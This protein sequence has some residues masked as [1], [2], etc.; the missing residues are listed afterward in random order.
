MSINGVSSSA[1][2]GGGGGDDARPA[3]SSNVSFARTSSSDDRS[4]ISHNTQNSEASL[5]QPARTPN[6]SFAITDDDRSIMSTNSEANRSIMSQNTQNSEASSTTSFA[7]SICSITSRDHHHHDRRKPPPQ[8]RRHSSQMYDLR[9]T[10]S[11]F[12]SGLSRGLSF[13]SAASTTTSSSSS[14]SRRNLLKRSSIRKS[15]RRLDSSHRLA[16]CASGS[17]LSQLYLSSPELEATDTLTNSTGSSGSRSNSSSGRRSSWIQ[18]ADIYGR[19]KSFR[20]LNSYAKFLD[21]EMMS[22]I[23]EEGSSDEEKM[24]LIEETTDDDDT[25][26]V[27]TKR[28]RR[29]CCMKWLKSP[30]LV[31]PT[32]MII[33]LI[34]G[35]GLSL[36]DS[37]LL[38]NVKGFKFPLCYALIQKLTNSLASLVLICLS[39]KWEMD[40]MAKQQQKQQ[41]RGN[42]KNGNVILTELPSIQTFRQHMIPLSAVALVQTISSAFANKALTIIPLPLFKVCLMCGPIFVAFIT[43]CVEGQLYSKGRLFALS[44]IGIGAA[45]AVYAESE[46]ADNPRYIMS[47]AGFA[48]AAS[49]FSGIGL[50]L[51]SVI[52]HHGSG[53]SGDADDDEEEEEDE[54]V[55]KSAVSKTENTSAELNPLSLLFY[56]SCVQ[57]L[58]L[59]G[60]LFPWDTLL[61][62]VG[63][64][65]IREEPGEFISFV[66]YAR[67]DPLTAMYYLMCGSM[68]SLTLAVLTFVL[69]NRTSPVATSLLGNARSIV[70]VAISSI[71]FGGGTTLASANGV[72][73]SAIFGYTLTLAGGVVY[74]LAALQS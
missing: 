35:V 2:K 15:L 59:S 47:G 16:C 1:H 74:A 54:H 24:L 40:A 22:D 67:A 11:A 36:Y 43:S 23:D 72:F 34:L 56:L 29:A 68:M 17:D 69:V 46:G 48:L 70:T 71:V 49:A 8:S 60:Y 30:M 58:M 38:R 61:A 44:L 5:Y 52:M 64:G 20:R 62:S 41:K 53:G 13:S 18:N 33:D 4:I 37:N 66:S 73:G 65:G 57:V 14:S 42:M 9:R 51:S 3:R 32:M 6:V 50:V 26:Y 39:R 10:F 45:R 28:K 12:S 25:D 19:R 63:G 31:V 27:P 7:S 21:A 55:S